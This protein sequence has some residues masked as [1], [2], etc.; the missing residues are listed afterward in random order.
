MRTWRLKEQLSA[1]SWPLS[2]VGGMLTSRLLRPLLHGTETQEKKIIHL[3]VRVSAQLRSTSIVGK[4]FTVL[5]L[6]VDLHSIYS[7]YYSNSLAQLW[8]ATSEASLSPLYHI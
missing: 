1:T 3:C 2:T 8:I 7:R 6:G 5:Q 4:N